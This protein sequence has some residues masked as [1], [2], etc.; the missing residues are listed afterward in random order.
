MILRL[1]YHFTFLKI[2]MGLG[3]DCLIQN[4]KMLRLKIWKNLKK[5]FLWSR[6]FEYFRK[7]MGS[8]PLHKL[9]N[10]KIE[11]AVYMKVPET[12]TEKFY[13]SLF[14]SKFVCF[15]FATHNAEPKNNYSYAIGIP[16]NPSNFQD[17]QWV[18]ITLFVRLEG[19]YKN[20]WSQ[21]IFFILN[22]AT[23]SFGKK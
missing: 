23:S 9:P 7:A 8:V 19:T 17:R 21:T 4:L 22:W 20:P 18:Q 5:Y 12:L 15:F 14:K 13:S 11:G 16:H 10:F 6:I 1:F 2:I 3:R